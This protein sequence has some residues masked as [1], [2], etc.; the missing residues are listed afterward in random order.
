MGSKINDWFL[1]LDLRQF[2]A[3]FVTQTV[4]PCRVELSDD[5]GDDDL[6]GEN[7][8][9]ICTLLDEDGLGLWSTLADG[10]SARCTSTS[11]TGGNAWRTKGIGKLG[12]RKSVFL[13]RIGS[14]KHCFR[15]AEAQESRHLLRT[16]N[17]AFCL[18]CVTG[19]ALSYVLQPTCGIQSALCS[20]DYCALDT[21]GAEPP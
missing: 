4:A 15:Q 10:T 9:Y 8:N 6:E 7:E 18:A 2:R 13:D 16:D 5:E 19:R 21:V 11:H 12:G 1:S 17:V 20:P 3:A 14:V